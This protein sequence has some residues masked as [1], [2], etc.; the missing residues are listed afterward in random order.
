M[1]SKKAAFSLFLFALAAVP[2]QAQD[3]G[4]GVFDEYGPNAAETFGRDTQARWRFALGGGVATDP[5]FQGSDKYRVHPTLFIFAGYGPFFIGFG[6]AGV[7]LYRVPGLR[8]GALI[9]LGAGRNESTD[10]RLAGLGD[11]DRTVLAG[12]FAVHATRS[13]LTR[14]ATYTDIGGEHHGT[15]ARLDVFGRFRTGER[16]GFFAGPGLT[17][18]NSPYNQTFFGVTDEQSLRAGFPAFSAGSGINN[19]RLTAG[20]NYRVAPNWRLLGGLTASRLAGDAAASPITEDK[21][22]YRAFLSAIYLFR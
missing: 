5:N 6:G 20:T 22:Q 14:V 8:M 17:W 11:V 16:F 4:A 15:L 12:L 19:V 7:N 18:G 3:A 10:A 21:M 9:S 13:F 1:P 2:A